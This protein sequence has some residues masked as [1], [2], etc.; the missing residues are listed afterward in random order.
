MTKTKM[1]LG[2]SVLLLAGAAFA[3]K[4]AQNVSPK[5]HPNIAAAQRLS[6][7]AY[8]KIVAAQKANEWDMKG[9]AQKAKELLEQVNNELKEAAQAANQA[10]K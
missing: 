4:P 7:Q 3:Q 9:H 1:L 6:E 5:H 10:H 2:A 8:E